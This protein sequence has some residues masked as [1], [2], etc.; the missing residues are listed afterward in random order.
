MI[1]Q[2]NNQKL[3]VFKIKKTNFAPRNKDCTL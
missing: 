3:T 1:K 2:I